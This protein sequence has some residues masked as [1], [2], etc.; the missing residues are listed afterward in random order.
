M[1]RIVS[2]GLV[3]ALALAGLSLAGGASDPIVGNWLAK[4]T[5]ITDK[6]PM[7]E[8]DQ[9][10][11]D[12]TYSANH[13]TNWNTTFSGRWKKKGGHYS[14]DISKSYENEQE[15]QFPGATVHASVKMTKIA[16]NGDV[17]FGNVRLRA[18]AKQAGQK[19]KV[20]QCGGFG[21]TRQ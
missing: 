12:I 1:I 2:L 5:L 15:S 8:L 19:L 9:F 6:G 4:A 17:Q 3:S 16:L 10:E 21:A 20:S 11:T 7:P 18:T 13:Q 14:F